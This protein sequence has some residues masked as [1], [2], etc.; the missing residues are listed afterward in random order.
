[1]IKIGIMGGTFDPIHNGHLQLAEHA[2]RQIGLDKILFIPAHIPWMKMERGIT[3]EKHRLAM[4]RLA[5]AEFPA[6]ELSAVEIDAGGITYTYRTLEALKRQYPEAEL[7]FILGADSLLSIEKW[8]HPEKIM[9]NAALLAA[10]RNDCGRDKLQKQRRLL[11]QKY[12]ARIILLTLSPIDISSTKIRKDFYTD[13]KA[14]AMLPVQVAAYI[15][16][17]QLYCRE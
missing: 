8:A 1:M 13:P 16:E 3:D 4:V 5:I 10:V 17:H 9:E 6:Y 7:Y 11:E 15:R 12:R 2:C 14:A